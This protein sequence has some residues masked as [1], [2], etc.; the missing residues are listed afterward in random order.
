MFSLHLYVISVYSG[1]FRLVCYDSWRMGSRGT[2]RPIEPVLAGN[3]YTCL[4]APTLRYSVQHWLKRVILTLTKFTSHHKRFESVVLSSITLWF[5]ATAFSWPTESLRVNLSNWT[6]EK[7]MLSHTTFKAEFSLERTAV[8]SRTKHLFQVMRLVL[9]CSRITE[10]SL[11][12]ASLWDSIIYLEQA[13]TVQFCMTHVRV[14][15]YDGFA[16]FKLSFAG[17]TLIW[18]NPCHAFSFSSFPC[19]RLYCTSRIII[20]HA[21]YFGRS[22]FAEH[23]SCA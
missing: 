21:N 18:S 6:Q 7:G 3:G 22:T 5:W 15:A 1:N 12:G 16:T 13:V 2:C 23:K 9:I 4:L 11:F 19:S 8:H 10:K 17:S 14:S 20:I